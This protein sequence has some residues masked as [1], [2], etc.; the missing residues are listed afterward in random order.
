MHVSKR[1]ILLLSLVIGLA[2]L[3]T[4]LGGAA[5]V[6]GPITF[7]PPTYTV[8]NIDGQ[9]GWMKTGPFDVEVEAVADYP[10]ASGYGFGTQALRMSNAYASGSF[11]DQTFSPA[12]SPAGEDAANHFDAS[13]WFGTAL[14][15]WQPGM[16]TSVSPD[17][18][19]GSRMTYLRF[20]DQIDG[21]HVFFVDVV[22]PGPY[23]MVSS[24]NEYPVATLSRTS[25]HS[26]GFSVD[27][28]DGPA[29][30]VV[31][32]YVDGS[33]VHTGTTWEDYYRYDPEQTAN[34]NVVP[35]VSKMLFREG[36]AS[37]PTNL[38]NGF[39]VDGLSLES[40]TLVGPPTSKEQCKNGGW[41]NF[42]NPTFRN[43]G[44]CVSYFNHQ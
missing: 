40:S 6:V 37:V 3:V 38:G 33:L 13:F 24:F 20:E 31:K 9:D 44:D 27:F 8:G 15:T 1:V 35:D 14:A 26:I 7:E 2:A 11:G 25:A 43:Q 17:D 34:G 23:P 21:V 42:N 30:D 22:N 39:L 10:A 18:G 19:N 36:G 29:N 12:T 4:P 5:P 16:V 32:I 41:R 28:Q